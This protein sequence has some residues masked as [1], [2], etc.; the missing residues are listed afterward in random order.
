M[1]RSIKQK[2]LVSIGLTLSLSIVIYTSFVGGYTNDTAVKSVYELASA[3][4]KYN[5]DA[6]TKELQKSLERVKTL[7]LIFQ[8]MARVGDYD[9]ALISDILSTMISSHGDIYE[10]IWTLWEPNA[11]DNQDEKYKNEANHD[12]SGR[13]NLHFYIDEKGKIIRDVNVNWFDASWYE[14]P[15]KM[16]EP[17]F[18]NPYVYPV[19]GNDVL[20]VS[21]IAP[22]II[23]GEFKG[24]VG[25]DFNL[26]AIQAKIDNLDIYGTNSL[27]L[28][29][30]DGTIIV[31]ENAEELDSEKL[32]KIKNGIN[33]S[34]VVNSE[35]FN[36]DH[37]IF[38]PIKL[39]GSVLPWS[40]MT[41][42]PYDFLL[43]PSAYMK[44]YT[45]IVGGIFLFFTLI[46]LAIVIE[47]VIARPVYLLESAVKK[48]SNEDYDIN[49]EFT[50]KDEIST[51]GKALNVMA[52]KIRITMYDKNVAE[53]NTRRLN[54][55]LERLV[56]QRT[57][58]LEQTNQQLIIEKNK[59]EENDRAKSQ[60]LAHMSHE[61]RTPLNG[62]IGI[63][64]LMGE[65]NLLPL[66]QEYITNSL[67]SAKSLLSILN[68]ILD[69]SKIES[70]LLI[71]ED[72]PNELQSSI[73]HVLNL[74]SP[75]ADESGIEFNVHISPDI[76]TNVYL[77][78]LRL[79]Q[80]LLNL[81]TNA[82]KFSNNGNVSLE[83]SCRED[84]MLLFKVSDSGIG[85]T[86]EQIKYI[87]KPFV[88]AESSTTRTFGGTGLGLTI[89]LA[90]AKL[91]SGSIE[92]KSQFGV[93]T[94]CLLILPYKTIGKQSIKDCVD[95]NVAV[96]DVYLKSTFRGD[97]FR[98]LL[99]DYQVEHNI[100]AVY[101]QND[102]KP[103]D[104]IAFVDDHFLSL[105]TEEQ[106]VSLGKDY[107]RIINV[108]MS[109]VDAN[110]YRSTEPSKLINLSWPIL[111]AQLNSV[112]CEQ[113]AFDAHKKSS[114]TQKNFSGVKVL[115]ADDV[116]INQMVVKRM[117]QKI[118][119]SMDVDI[120]NN[121]VDVLKMVERKDYDI[122]LM[123]LSMPVMD[124]YE[125][126]K[127]L[128]ESSK[129]SHIPI[130]GLTADAQQSTRD[131]C[132]NNGMAGFI[133][134][135]FEPLE[136][137]KTIQELLGLDSDS[138]LANNGPVNNSV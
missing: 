61:I 75:I 33:F 39:K 31:G 106:Q 137:Q 36:Q 68:D 128:K 64:H 80:I 9:R 51:L 96:V 130:V 82:I 1:L 103:T 138:E 78:Q 35:L 50:A 126:T 135:P 81:L 86:E 37:Q 113:R 8:D 44:R 107:K 67:N 26:A 59:A 27:R 108:A 71:I 28:L 87:F 40:L 84:N 4:A 136:L 47:R 112:L 72:H 127:K 16:M 53:D 63:H 76:S 43:Q 25:L 94:E 17:V 90:L 69:F 48:I 14:I 132:F 62:I 77:D 115:V 119:K 98:L 20:L 54:N 21:L 134:K 49:V 15:K 2:L 70:G 24:V 65:T 120:A 110:H 32:E 121:G 118:D 12:L 73:L 93:G 34:G 46:I 38:T 102:K 29:T 116:K 101:N 30:N 109:T 99:D 117:L 104:A 23:D 89:S 42:I 66:Q 7:S 13:V 11:F 114:W 22:L 133:V 74:I 60:F 10:G 79:I 52:E 41:T 18:L 3:N 122:I 97:T 57:H 131:E 5:A 6:V 111:P 55:K 124:G 100:C 88:Q 56:F 92:I 125:A 123:D 105:L 45:V 58:E 129:F 83:I 91:M 95:H 85:M 19:A